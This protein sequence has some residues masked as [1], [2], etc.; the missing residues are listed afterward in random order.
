MQSRVAGAPVHLSRKGRGS[1]IPE[2]TE[3]G[4]W[5]P[6]AF[7]LGEDV[8]T[9]KPAT[10]LGTSGVGERLTCCRALY[11]SGPPIA[12]TSKIDIH[13][14]VGIGDVRDLDIGEP[15]SVINIAIHQLVVPGSSPVI[16]IPSSVGRPCHRSSSDIAQAIH[17][18]TRISSKKVRLVTTG[19]TISTVPV[20][21]H[22]VRMTCYLIRIQLGAEVPTAVEVDSDR[23]ALSQSTEGRHD[24]YI[25]QQSHYHTFR[26]MR[27]W[28]TRLWQQDVF[29]GFRS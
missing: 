15:S 12:I 9:G 17:K 20:I 4:N 3:V 19:K 25:I 26:I 10:L 1:L 8:R 6:S 11:R 14:V 5:V 22:H 29:S 21:L 16:C 2:Y 28:L 24:Q 18:S 27:F 7:I 13:I 23:L